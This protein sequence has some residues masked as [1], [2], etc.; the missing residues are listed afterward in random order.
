ML[1]VDLHIHSVASYHAYGTIYDIC[2]TAFE[3]KMKVV[4][5]S[6]HGPFD[7][8]DYQKWHFLMG[9]SAPKYIN[10]VR[11][12]W[13]GELNVVKEN[14]DLDLPLFIQERMD[15][16]MFGYHKPSINVRSVSKKFFNLNKNELTKVM[17]KALDNPFVDIIAHPCG[18]KAVYD[19]E[20]VWLKAIDK[21]VLLELNCDKLKGA[22]KE[23]LLY[24]KKMV[25][26]VKSNKKKLIIGSDAHFLHEIGDDSII[27]K[28]WDFLE[29]DKKIILNE[30]LKQVQ[31]FFGFEL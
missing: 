11:L 10:G 15:Y 29:L 21:N 16:V 18:K 23:E 7:E 20:K 9:Y 25:A 2:K 5:I 12:L 17:L 13:G 3:N 27:K 14:G 1:S 4:G 22:S 28:Y 26:V 8:N 24:F 6:D 31:E 30:N 19:Q